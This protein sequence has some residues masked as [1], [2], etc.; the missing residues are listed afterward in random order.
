MKNK[1]LSIYFFIY[2]KIIF[3]DLLIN[4]FKKN[5][6]FL[7]YF[8]ISCI[9][10]FFIF[11]N[12]SVDDFE[13]NNR[14]RDDLF[15]NTTL[16]NQEEKDS[17]GDGLYDW[18]EVLYRTDPED[19]DSDGDGVSDGDEVK[20]GM[21]PNDFGAGKKDSIEKIEVIQENVLTLEKQKEELEEIYNRQSNFYQRLEELKKKAELSN[22]EKIF[23]LNEDKR[24]QEIKEVLNNSGKIIKNNQVEISNNI[25]VFNNLFAFFTPKNNQENLEKYIEE[26]SEYSEI[27]DFK[28]EYRKFNVKEIEN[29]EN[30]AQSFLSIST[31]LENQNISNFDLN[32]LHKNLYRSY[33]RMGDSILEMVNAAKKGQKSGDISVILNYTS[34]VSLNT[35]SRKDI[36]VFLK[37]NNVDFGSGDSGN[38][39]VYSL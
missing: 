15:K 33:K 30:L 25:E 10:L 20:R 27:L 37:V 12:F 13:K 11:Q 18:Q 22:E 21:D 3:M 6:I 4:F 7:F 19:K 32:F 9:L 26:N 2:V 1:Y 14:V 35:R 8:F 31:I 39:F 16:E 36:H 17:D 34:A 38:M 24:R 5:Q 29:L 28:I 23:I